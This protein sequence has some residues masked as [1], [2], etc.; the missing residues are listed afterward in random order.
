MCGVELSKRTAFSFLISPWR[1][2]WLPELE[3]PKTHNC[4]HLLSLSG[5]F[6]SPRVLYSRSVG[7]WFPCTVQLSLIFVRLRCEQKKTTPTLTL[8][9]GA[10]FCYSNRERRALRMEIVSAEV[11]PM[12]IRPLLIFRGL[13]H[14]DWGSIDVW[15]GSALC[16]HHSMFCSSARKTATHSI[17]VIKHAC[18]VFVFA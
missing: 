17:A 16:A 1:R 18:F 7:R 11:S 12:M 4:C 13:T 8:L 5:S 9:S 6:V 3:W 14:F 10:P 2:T 15:F